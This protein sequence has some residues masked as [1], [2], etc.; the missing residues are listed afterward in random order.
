MFDIDKE[1]LLELN[2]AMQKTILNM[3]YDNPVEVSAFAGTMI[4][5]GNQINMQLMKN[6]IKDGKIDVQSMKNIIFKDD[7]E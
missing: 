2:H 6:T 4:S 7:E 1:S 3:D 5:I